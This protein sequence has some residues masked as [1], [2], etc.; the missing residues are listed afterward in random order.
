[1]NRVA[2][3]GQDHVIENAAKLPT[4]LPTNAQRD[5]TEQQGSPFDLDSAR[6]TSLSRR[7]PAVAL[8]LAIVLAAVAGVA[9][10][11]ARNKAGA[12]PNAIQSIAVLPFVDDSVDGDAEFLDDEIAESL[13]N[14]LTKLP[15]LR[16]VPRA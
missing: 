8:T 1:M 12:S 16:V 14:S 3:N 2:E 10:L 6:W 5:S 11:S 9:Y 15:K 13:V 4:Q 7:L